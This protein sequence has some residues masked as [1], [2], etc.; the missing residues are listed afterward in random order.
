MQV[1]EEQA[2]EAAKAIAD[3][4]F[5]HG[6]AKT[7]LRQLAAAANVSDRML[8]YYFG[9]KAEALRAGALKLAERFADDLRTRD[10]VP[11]QAT[12]EELVEIAIGLFSDDQVKP[13][14]RLWIDIISAAGHG[15]VPYPDV[16]KT[17][18]R[19]LIGWIDSRLSTEDPEQRAQEAA[20]IL[21][22]I[23]GLA[24]LGEAAGE[25]TRDQA[26]ACLMP[27]LTSAN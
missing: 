23:D 8:V 26:A 27:R 22:M 17:I 24:L 11:D 9:S 16:V 6:L 7:S 19:F 21:A 4:L 25:E 1:R 2:A 5:E 12:F 18:S 14:M 3:H 20:G 15:V 13:F 10:Q